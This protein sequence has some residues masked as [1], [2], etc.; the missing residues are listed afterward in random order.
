MGLIN[1]FIKAVGAS[2]SALL[3]LLPTT[4]FVWDL[5]GTSAALTWIRWIFP[6]SGFVISMGVYVTA[7]ASYYVLR[8]ALRWIKVVGS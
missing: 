3:S 8:V 7:V 4:P 6:I 2:I 1:L 5:N